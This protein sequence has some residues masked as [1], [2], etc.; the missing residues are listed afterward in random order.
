[1]SDIFLSY[2]SSDLDRAKVL[3]EALE[4]QGWTVFFDRTVPPGESRRHYIGK[5]IEACRCMIVVW[6]T[7]SVN[8]DLVKVEAGIGL[9]RQI[10][11]PLLLDQV[12]PPQE[13]GF[14]QAEN[15]AGWMGETDRKSTRLNS[16]HRCN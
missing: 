7:H 12:N 14:I 1:M 4:S 11:V 6:S 8:S 16:S 5:E 3:A 13:F 10:L 2:D 15:L 9:K